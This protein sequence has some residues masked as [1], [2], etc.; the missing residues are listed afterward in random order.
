MRAI[1]DPWQQ[2]VLTFFLYCIIQYIFAL[3]GYQF[4]W[5]AY[6]FDGEMCEQLWI[7]FLIHYDMTFKYDGGVGGYLDS[8]DPYAYRSNLWRVLFDFGA[9]FVLAII[10]MQIISGIIIDT[11]GLLRDQE[12]EKTKDKKSNC[13]ICGLKRYFYFFKF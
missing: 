5:K 8:F 12:M 11:F 13:F 10:L 6:G 3:L 1:T 4:F 2:L 9:F 7:C